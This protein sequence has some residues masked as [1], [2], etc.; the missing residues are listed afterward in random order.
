MEGWF[1]VVVLMLYGCGV[2]MGDMV[3]NL[4]SVVVLCWRF[5]MVVLSFGK[6]VIRFFLIWKIW[7]MVLDLGIGCSFWLF[8][9]GNFLVISC[10]VMVLLSV[11]LFLCIGF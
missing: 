3:V 8:S 1:G 2:V 10:V 5:V 7:F 11:S 6:C 9:L 4:L